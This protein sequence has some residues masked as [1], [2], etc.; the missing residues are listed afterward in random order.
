MAEF[1]F[2]N[3]NAEMYDLMENVKAINK[4]LP[5][6]RQLP[7]VLFLTLTWA[8]YEWR[9]MMSS[10]VSG[11]RDEQLEWLEWWREKSGYNDLH[12]IKD[13]FAPF[14]TQEQN[15]VIAAFEAWGSVKH[16]FEYLAEAP[17]EIIIVKVDDCQEKTVEAVVVKPNYYL[18]VELNSSV[19]AEWNLMDE[20]LSL[21]EFLEKNVGPVSAILPPAGDRARWEFWFRMKADAVGQEALR[22]VLSGNREGNGNSAREFI[23]TVTAP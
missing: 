5:P 22:F 4:T 20:Q 16:Y 10:G 11:D 18:R 14:L 7:E 2:A 9:Q 15:D 17:A 3:L 1:E 6:Q 23:L 8:I 12:F 21:L 13:R 19:E